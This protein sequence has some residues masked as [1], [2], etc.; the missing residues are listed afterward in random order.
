MSVGFGPPVDL[1]ATR[2]MVAF[3]LLEEEKLF[4]HMFGPMNKK[5]VLFHMV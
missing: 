1:D 5:L 3:I 2:N 4:Q